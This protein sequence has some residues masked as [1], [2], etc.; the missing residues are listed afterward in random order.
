[1]QQKQKI[2][3]IWGQNHCKRFHAHPCALSFSLLLETT[4][5][6]SWP[7]TPSNSMAMAFQ[8]LIPQKYILYCFQ[9]AELAFPLLF[10]VQSSW[11]CMRI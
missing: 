5:F 4:F 7:S 11:V 6:A 10:A 3:S 2:L 8:H 1:M 9:D